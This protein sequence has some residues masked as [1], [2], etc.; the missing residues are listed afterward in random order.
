MARRRLEDD[1]RTIADM[2]QVPGSGMGGFS[3]GKNN[4]E[5]YELHPG[6]EPYTRRE[7]FRYT[8][9]AL[10]AGLLI[11]FAYIAGLGLVIALL[12]LVWTVL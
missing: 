7:R 6:Q 9:A 4:Q 3:P 5:R 12:L 11:A 8:M 2:S 1:G 10:K